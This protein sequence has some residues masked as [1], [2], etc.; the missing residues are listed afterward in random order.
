[1]TRANA[2][3]AD[4]NLTSDGV[5]TYAY[6]YGNRLVGASRPGMT[7]TYAYDGETKNVGGGAR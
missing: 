6:T 4:G 3:D 1:M 2:F 5:N 7:A